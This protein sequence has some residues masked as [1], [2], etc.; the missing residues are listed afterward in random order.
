MSMTP[1]LRPYILLSPTTRTSYR[2]PTQYPSKYRFTRFT[3]IT[4]TRSTFT[5]TSTPKG[6][7]LFSSS[8]DNM[9]EVTTGGGYHAG[10]YGGY[11]GGYHGNYW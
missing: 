6:G 7:T 10:G 1:R 9:N 8:T 11:H 5:T 4:T 2:Y 3:S